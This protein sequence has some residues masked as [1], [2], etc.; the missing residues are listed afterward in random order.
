MHYLMLKKP[1][2]LLKLAFIL[3]CF[4]YAGVASADVIF[5]KSCE[6][7]PN[8]IA[9]IRLGTSLHQIKAIYPNAKLARVTDGDGV[10]LVSVTV[11]NQDLAVLYAGE[12][13]AS[14]K[15]NFSK[16]I[17]AIETFN[18]MCKTKLSISPKSALK[19]A[20]K[21]LGG[22][23]QI[24]MSEIEGRQY[25]KFK[26]QSGN[27]IYRINYCG[28]FANDSMRETNKYLPDCVILSIAIA[29]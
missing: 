7:T 4:F 11:G 20:A 23:E 24:R 25:V 29:N 21:L 5:P 19:K 28:D 18:S 8:S 16:K 27:L 13:D 10:A 1:F 17:Q 6:I 14:E 2:N 9:K 12:E 26:K 15:I 22:I 3:N